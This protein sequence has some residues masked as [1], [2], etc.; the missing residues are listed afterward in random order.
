M[1]DLAQAEALMSKL[2]AAGSPPPGKS[3]RGV[4]PSLPLELERARHKVAAAFAAFEREPGWFD[5][6]SRAG[7]V[8]AALSSLSR[9]LSE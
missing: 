2:R 8:G 3:D 6:V 1:L 4:D 5:Q 9:W 7:L